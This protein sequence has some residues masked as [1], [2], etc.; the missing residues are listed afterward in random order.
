M[1]IKLGR[2]LPKTPG[3]HLSCNRKFVSTLL[4]I[5][6]T[7]PSHGFAGLGDEQLEVLDSV[8]ASTHRAIR[9][10]IE[11]G[12]LDAPEVD[13]LRS[14]AADS[15]EEKDERK[16]GR[17]G[18]AGSVPC[19][20]ASI[21][22]TP[23]E[24]AH[25]REALIKAEL[26]HYVNL[27]GLRAMKSNL[28]GPG[29]LVFHEAVDLAL[30]IVTRS[31][32]FWVFPTLFDGLRLRCGL[33]IASQL[34]VPQGGKT[35][36]FGLGG[37][38]ESV[39]SG[40]ETVLDAIRVVRSVQFLLGAM[41]I[42][43]L[44]YLGAEAPGSQELDMVHQLEARICARLQTCR[45]LYERVCLVP[46]KQMRTILDIVA[47]FVEN[48][49]A[50]TVSGFENKEPNEE[51][52]RAYLVIR[53]AFAVPCLRPLCLKPLEGYDGGDLSLW[54]ACQHI[55]LLK[56]REAKT[57]DSPIS[58]VA[59]VLGGV[60][61]GIT[62]H[63][64]QGPFFANDALLEYVNRL[65]EKWPNPKTRLN[66][67]EYEDCTPEPLH[68]SRRKIR[69]HV[70]TALTDTQTRGKHVGPNQSICEAIRGAQSETNQK[71]SP[72][73]KSARPRSDLVDVRAAAALTMC[74]VAAG[75]ERG[76]RATSCSTHPTDG[77]TQL[78]RFYIVALSTEPGLPVVKGQLENANPFVE[79]P[80][81]NRAS[82]SAATDAI[83]TP[84]RDI[85]GGATLLVGPLYEFTKQAFKQTLLVDWLPLECV[86]QAL[87]D[88]AEGRARRP[89]A[90]MLP[91]TAMAMLANHAKTIV[92]RVVTDVLNRMQMAQ[93]VPPR[94][95]QALECFCTWARAV[96]DHAVYAPL[97]ESCLIHIC[98]STGATRP[99]TKRWNYSWQQ[100]A[101]KRPPPVS[102]M[103]S[104]EEMRRAVRAS[105]PLS[106]EKSA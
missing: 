103:G 59:Q 4:Q 3:E 7:L 6:A 36:P 62:S 70:N 27:R 95:K 101:L 76:E 50:A 75:L 44:Q 104:A 47:D 21:Q 99:S 34:G 83:E 60:V 89:Q 66:W 98:S 48:A 63:A 64:I 88:R 94:S 35:R 45:E 37:C 15:E 74:S 23:Q 67:P 18:V 105:S 22:Y 91:A 20:F 52:E 11:R 56:Q 49:S 31:M 86:K 80:T 38:A 87:R 77:I 85:V 78:K 13:L 19:I 46:G 28:L 26:A 42:G 30:P 39:L 73:F 9:S 55:L 24:L 71:P 25:F 2:A 43:V 92:A 106:L 51:Q 14:L 41:H 33:E 12:R 93:G 61:G 102:T 65:I 1:L 57:T 90:A 53:L 97:W 82:D 40:G 81:K 54:D 58:L 17:I 69:R 29:K 79:Q 96:Y 100:N 84:W 5:G 8:I 32:V 10:N 68:V 16:Y 72:R